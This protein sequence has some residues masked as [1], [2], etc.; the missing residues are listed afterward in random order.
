MKLF[1]IVKISVLSALV[2]FSQTAVAQDATEV[3]KVGFVDVQAVFA[4]IP[5]TQEANKIL[6]KEAKKR[7]EE[8]KSLTTEVKALG[9]KVTRDALT[10]SDEERIKLQEELRSKEQKL[11]LTK[12]IIEEDMKIMQSQMIRAVRQRIYAAVNKIATE[13]KFDMI[14]IEGVLFSNS[15]VNLTQQVIDFMTSVGKKGKKKDK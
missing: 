13:E 2:V 6:E 10:M 1:N 15:K 14:L 3:L 9:E 8:F 7:E 11:R 5:Q 12:G 4:K